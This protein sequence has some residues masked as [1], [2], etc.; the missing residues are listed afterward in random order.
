MTERYGNRRVPRLIAKVN[1]HRKL[2]ASEGSPAIQDS[3]S[4]IE[5]FIDFI[6]AEVAKRD[7]N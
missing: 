7:P 4:Q 3:W 6:Y 5:E 2:V 1:E